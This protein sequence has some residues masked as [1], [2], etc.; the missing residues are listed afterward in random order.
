[1]PSNDGQTTAPK[2]KNAP[3][4]LAI[5][6]G[7]GQAPKGP[8][9]AVALA[10]TPFFDRARR[11]YPFT[12]LQSHGRYVGLMPYQEGNSEAGHMNIGAG[13]VVRQDIVNVTEAIKDGT[14]FKNT[15]F[16]ETLKHAQKYGT[17][18]HLMGMLANSNS[19]HASPEHLYALLKLCRDE[20]ISQVRL[21]L[22]TDGRDSPPFTATRLLHELEHNLSPG[23][24]IGS[25][26]GRFYAMDRNK[27]WNRTELAYNAIVAGEGLVAPNAHTAILRGYNRGE[28]DEFI[29]PTVMI[30]ADKRPIGTVDDNDVVIFFNLRSDR[31]R[32]LT[33]C[34]VQRDFEK[35][36]ENSFK[37][38]KTPRNMRFA[39]M[40]EFGPDLEHVYTA[41][42]SATIE[43][44]LTETLAPYR[45]LYIAE[46]EKYAHVTYF[47]NGGF[48]RPR[49]GE[50]RMR[51]PSQFVP[52]HDSLPEMRARV[53]ADEVVRRVHAKTHDLIV[54]NF[55]NADMVGHTG[56]L[57]AT[58]K[59]IEYV[60]EC[61]TKLSEAANAAGGCLII[62]GDHG[63]A[64]KK[65]NEETGEIMT[66]HTDNPVPFLIACEKLRSAKL[67]DGMLAD[68]APTVLDIMNIPKPVE[69]TG[70]SLLRS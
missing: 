30:D 10:H 64:E 41:F 24:Q 50:E 52:H 29:L 15:A 8:G 35:R 5:L 21:H 60:D 1:M 23:Q 3:V 31:A 2:P 70:F 59:A 19:A 43:H 4:V 32:Q 26:M 57:K 65:I 33:K 62:V 7:W 55:A 68:V 11:R 69:M 17:K 51:V 63:N 42:P 47:F 27:L 56:N 34:F 37:R 48:D 22:F 66:E 39:A 36:N 20:A 46:S 40:S 44:G 28:S 9:N 49:F 54:I 13:R 67:G 45:Q 53:I 18:V 6:D 58:V 12:T 38:R 16:K 14:F 61:L 25:V